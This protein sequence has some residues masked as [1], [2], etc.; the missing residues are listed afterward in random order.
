MSRAKAPA[1]DV[2]VMH[3]ET[4]R[5]LLVLLAGSGCTPLFFHL[6][7][8][9]KRLT[10]TR[11]TFALSLMQAHAGL[12][13][14]TVEKVGVHSFELYSGDGMSDCSEEYER[15]VAKPERVRAV[16]DAI[17][18]L[19]AQPWVTQVLLVGHSEGADVAAGVTRLL[20]EKRVAAV[21]IMA[22]AG[23]SQLFDE[24]L[25]A[26][27]DAEPGGVRAAFDEVLRVTDPAARGRWNGHS[28]T[29]WRSY[30]VD[31]TPLEELR[32]SRV[33]V[34]IAHGSED[35][36]VPI[37]SADLLAVELMRDRSR[38][39]FYLYLPGHDHSFRGKDRADD[40][41]AVLD[42]F[43]EWALSPMKAT[44]VQEGL[45]GAH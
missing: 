5:P 44:G 6:E 36:S 19:A 14:A 31:T 24:V 34:F 2:Y 43:L 28:L 3:D 45:I 32:A 39:V 1:L 38:P 4:P 18:A 33:P 11:L 37:E 35:E 16:A 26:R 40:A 15:H 29:R 27:R 10:G 12:H 9:G 30:A 41:R 42:R 22:G 17:T 23:P 25:F 20:G 7:R 13:V 21:G 8:E